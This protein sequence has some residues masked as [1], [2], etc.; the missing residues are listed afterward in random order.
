VA[1]DRPDLG[2][3]AHRLTRAIAAAEAPVLEAHG[4]TMW[5]Y[6]VL[7]AL[8]SGPAPT[9]AQLAVGTGRDQ[10]RL[11]PL[12]EGLEARGLLTRTPDP[13]DRRRRVVSLE[14][15]GRALLADVRGAIRALEE[16]LLADLDPADR[17]PF[18]R[19]LRRLAPGVA[20]RRRQNSSSSRHTDD[21]ER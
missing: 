14:P 16:R 7:S 10:T 11:I 12:L 13:D 8:G 3:L 6:V 4:L 17:D 20:V 15:A 5:E 9:Q 21:F 18:V 2:V 19:A 1:D